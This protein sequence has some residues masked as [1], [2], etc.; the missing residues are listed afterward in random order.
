MVEETN[1]PE[2]EAI[3]PEEGEEA[4]RKKAEEIEAAGK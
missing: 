4:L 2:P 3:K 1:S